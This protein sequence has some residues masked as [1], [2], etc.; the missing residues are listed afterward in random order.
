MTAASVRSYGLLLRW[1]LQRNRQLLVL[2]VAIQVALGVG[3]IYGFS[4]LVPRI[5]PE[6]AVFFATGAPTLS[7]IL[8]GLTVVPQETA[9]SRTNGRF[10][11]VAALPVPRLAPMLADVTFW[12]LVQLPGWVVTL[13]LAIWHFHLHL[14]VD[15]WVVP[16]VALVSLSAAAVGYAVAVSFPPGAVGQVSQFLS[17]ALLLFS[18]INFPLDRLPEWLQAVHRGLPVTYM[19]DL[20]RGGL[21]G[22]YDDS[23]LLAFAVVSTYCA[24][25]LAIAARAARRRL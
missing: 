19:A 20:V 10:A 25:G 8:I 23:R 17:I 6:V 22:R 1:Q 15:G 12:L 9:L 18:P 16:A 21:T 24:L 13:A 14:R 4:F 3:M 11:Y 2:L 5:T 7:M